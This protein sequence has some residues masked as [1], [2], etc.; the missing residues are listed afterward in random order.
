MIASEL[1]IAAPLSASSSDGLNPLVNVHE[2]AYVVQ[3]ESI[4]MSALQTIRRRLP[5][6]SW[7]IVTLGLAFSVVL[8]FSIWQVYQE[9]EASMHLQ[10]SNPWAAWQL[11][12]EHLR[13]LLAL[14]RFEMSPSRA[15]LDDLQLRYEI[16]Y[17]RPQVILN[18]P[19][20]T[21]LRSLPGVRET[22]RALLDDLDAMEAQIY[23]LST[24]DTS[25]VRAVHAALLPYM[26]DLSDISAGA[27]VGPIAQQLREGM[28]VAQER[29]FWMHVLLVSTAGIMISILTVEVRRNRQL[30]EAESRLRAQ[31][32][33]TSEALRESERRYRHIVEGTE[34]TP[35]TLD[36]S[37]MSHQFVGPQARRLLGY[38][39]EKWLA[40]DFWAEHLHSD[41]RDQIVS[42]RLHYLQQS[43]E[44]NLEYRMIN[45]NGRTVWIRDLL[46]V[47]QES[48]GRLLGYGLLFD[49]TEIK[50]RDQKLAAAQK[51]EAIGQLTGG[52]AHDFNNL[53][54]VVIG[55]L[56]LIGAKRQCDDRTSRL[57]G[58][59][60]TAA[61]R[62]AGL[63][64]QLLGFARKQSLEPQDFNPNELVSTT[65]ELIRRTLGEQITINTS[66]ESDLWHAHA[67][68]TQVESAVTNLAIN[69]RD[70]MPNGGRIT[71]ETANRCFSEPLNAEYGRIAPGDY[72]VISVADTGTGIPPDMLP[73]VF[74]PFFTTK[75]EGKG[76]GLGLSMVFG[77]VQQS[78][79]HVEIESELGE[80][81]T[82]RIYLPRVRSR[83]PANA[84]TSDDV[85]KGSL[86]G[87]RVLVVEDSEGVRETAVTRLRALGCD[88]IE[89]NNG[90]VG[91]EIMKGDHAI[92]LLFTD[93]VMPGGM[94]GIE[95]AEAARRVRP[96]LRVLFTSGFYEDNHQADRRIAAI[97]DM[98]RKPYTS[99]DMLRTF[100][101]A[102]SAELEIVD[103][104][105]I[106]TPVE[107]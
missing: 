25:T 47:V 61:E 49:E 2:E 57:L 85:Q 22:A 39:L 58:R 43:D 40:E 24:D 105:A 29:S 59:A 54:T 78:R 93:L 71:I 102:L 83:G 76:T 94:S 50:L 80:G 33:E 106:L 62:G 98:L 7:W 46:K 96:D 3:E 75:G 42:D 88:V 67:D 95:L 38:P 41:D 100:Q 79:G 74:D 28:R 11:E 20:T 1:A 99:L 19:E 34:A 14:Q 52:M 51:M 89:A 104:H 6:R 21:V 73:R 26:S 63:I 77:F 60:L 27:S 55:N 91:L 5:R 17:S 31:A 8:T 107:G 65:V 48:T 4:R 87:A 64:K 72:V 18:G 9:R 81:T 69:A 15:A 45:A 97:G 56:E 30:A 70:A 68:A 32:D 35:Y 23:G 66:L 53:L 36:L 103:R 13:L 44:L 101:A 12:R 84:T 16:L 90:A 86:E 10:N 82:V 92:D 37:T